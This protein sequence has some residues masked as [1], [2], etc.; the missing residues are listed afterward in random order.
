MPVA[1]VTSRKSDILQR[2]KKSNMNGSYDPRP[3]EYRTLGNSVIEELCCNLLSCNQ[4]SAWFQLV[5]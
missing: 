5:L 1:E 3:P 2:N 4:P